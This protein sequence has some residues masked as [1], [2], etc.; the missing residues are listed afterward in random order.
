MSDVL[1]IGFG[2]ELMGDDGAGP[3]A[4][5]ELAS[6]PPEISARVEDGGTDALTLPSWWRGERQIW[7]IDAVRSGHLRVHQTLDPRGLTYR[8]SRDSEEHPN[9][10]AIIISRDFGAALESVF[11]RDMQASREVTLAE[12]Q[13]RGVLP[14]LKEAVSRL[15]AYWL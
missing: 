12:W 8:E 15:F 11:E 13:R 10:N 3:A 7:I 1:I 14:R 5:R 6:Q 2:N 4:I 9:S